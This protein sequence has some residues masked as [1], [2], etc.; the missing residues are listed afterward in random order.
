MTNKVIFDLELIK[1]YDRSGPRYTSYPTA[2][3]MTPELGVNAYRHTARQTNTGETSRPL[4]LYFHLPFCN[5]VCYY[6]G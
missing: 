5:T 3:Q 4:S 2:P 1:R 6:C